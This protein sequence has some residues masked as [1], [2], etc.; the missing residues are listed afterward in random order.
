MDVQRLI[1]LFVFGFSVLLLWEGWQRESRPKPAPQPAA[2]VKREIT[3]DR[4]SKGKERTNHAAGTTDGAPGGLDRRAFLQAGAL[5]GAG[6]IEADEARQ[7]DAALADILD[8]GRADP[9]YVAGP[10]EDV[11]SFVE[12]MLVETAVSP[13]R[14]EVT[15]INPRVRSGERRKVVTGIP[16]KTGIV[17]TLDAAT[18][19]FLWARPTV[20][21]NVLQSI[22]GTTGEFTVNPDAM[23]VEIGQERHICPTT[24]GGKNWPSGTLSPLGNVMFFP[25]QNTCM[26]STPTLSR[27]SPDSLYGLNNSNEIAGNGANVGTIQAISV[28]TGKTLW[29]YEQRAGMMSLLS[30]AGGLVFGG[31]TNG[32]FRAFD[33]RTDAKMRS[34]SS[35][36]MAITAQASTNTP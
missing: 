33:Q 17:Y 34:R 35:I 21:Q 24:L 26:T 6:V 22:D 16:G 27:P 31:D 2:P 18:G 23:F 7:I 5:A 11:H 30:T 3:M 28:E 12:R 20:Q 13:D 4:R 14:S 9:A 8:R 25:L 10:D 1:L 36:T 19:E 15:W 32:R 29:K